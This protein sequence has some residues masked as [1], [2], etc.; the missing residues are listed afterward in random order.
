MRSKISELL[1]KI[2]RLANSSTLST[3]DIDLLK[4]HV[5]DLYEVV[6]VLQP[7]AE[8]KPIVKEVVKSEPVIVP[9][10]VKEPEELPVIKEIV[11]EV[12]P[13]ASTPVKEKEV[14]PV[15]KKK[16]SINE[17]TSAQ[18]TLN[19]KLKP[20]SK[21]ELHQQLAVKPLKELININK[22]FVL[23]REL[24]GGNADAFTQ[25]VDTIDAAAHY[26]EA[27]NYIHQELFATHHWEGTA[28]PTR[29]FIKLVKQKFGV[30]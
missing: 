22:R 15:A 2:N 1:E 19:E 24:F 27:E 29:L 20:V 11:K 3:I 8:A 7:E 28:Q 13:V 9:V 4:Q 10:P 14:K 17:S 16:V 26:E 5:R 6:L 18:D 25:A 21:S 23:V 12:A 30:E